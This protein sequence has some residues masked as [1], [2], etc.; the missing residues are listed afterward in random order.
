MGILLY[1]LVGSD[2]RRPFSPHC[3]KIALAL[4][5]K[6]LSFEGRPTRFTEIADI[7]NGVTKTVPLIR[8]GDRLIR[9]SFA[10]ALYLEEAYPDRP[11]LFG[12]EG[13]KA[14]ARFVERWSQLTLHTFI[15]EAALVDIHGLLG[16][17]DQVYFRESREARFG[18]PLEDVPADRETRLEDFRA[19]LAPL[20]T[21]FRHQPFIGGEGP[22]FADYIVAGA[23]QWA[24][25]ASPFPFLAPD[26]PV[27]DWFGRCLDLHDGLARRV[28]A[29]A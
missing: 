13:G 25:V 8:D 3:W 24:R 12:G 7:E 22:L 15:G 26:D 5:H 20:R 1:E 18:K 10:I 6:G 16:P 4:A 21:L 9:G 27:A 29:A 28:P 17:E 14:M 11:T 19:T 2:E 23:L